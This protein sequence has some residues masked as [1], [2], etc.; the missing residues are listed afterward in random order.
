MAAVTQQISRGTAKDTESSA[1]GRHGISTSRD[2]TNNKNNHRH[3]CYVTEQL[4]YAHLWIL[5][6]LELFQ[7]KVVGDKL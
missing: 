3:C 2:T 1:I 7:E 6:L 4:E 5:V